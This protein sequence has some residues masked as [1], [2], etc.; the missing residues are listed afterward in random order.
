M[1]EIS[2]ECVLLC[3]RSIRIGTLYFDSKQ[4]KEHW[5]QPQTMALFERIKTV[6]KVHGTM[7]WEGVSCDHHVTM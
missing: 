6:G 3:F 4:L 1:Y 5:S 7:L 2:C